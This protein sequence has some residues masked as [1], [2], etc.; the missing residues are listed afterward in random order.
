M[1]YVRGNEDVVGM[2]LEREDIDPNTADTEYGRT[3]LLWGG[4]EGIVKLLLD[5]EDLHPDM[6]NPSNE[7]AL[8]LA[9][10][11][12]HLGVVQ[13]LSEPKSSL[14]IPIDIEQITLQQ[15]DVL[16]NNKKRTIYLSEKGK[17]RK[18]RKASPI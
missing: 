1:G 6:P 13:L 10:S 18:K 4:Y 14:P 15:E 2:L 11:Q 17:P 7:T 9:A 12:G 8:E 5:R 16:D 3:P